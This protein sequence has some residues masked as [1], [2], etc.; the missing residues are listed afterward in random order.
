MKL[1][2]KWLKMLILFSP[3]LLNAQSIPQIPITAKFIFT[4]KLQQ[5][6]AVTLQNTVIKYTPGGDSSYREQYR[7]SNN[8]LGELGYIDA[9][10]PFNLLLYYPDY[11]LVVTLDRTLNQTGSFSLIEVG[12]VQAR[13]VGLSN[14]GNIW[15]YDDANFLLQKLNRLGESLFKSQNLS[16]VLPKMPQPIQLIARE[17]FVYLN[18]P[19]LGILVFD[20]FGQYYKTIPILDIIGF[21]ILDNRIIY[22][23]QEQLYWYDLK[24]FRID[25]LPL[26]DGVGTEDQVQVQQNQLFVRKKAAI[27]VYKMGH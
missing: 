1:N 16:L 3:Y 19:K 22:Q 26:P 13:A 14:D 11:Q 24:S 25:A 21:Q 20:T 6:Y 4:D 9:T 23:N 5:I 2:M 27:E 7:F 12:V 10:D 18:D 15:V 8:T 17:N